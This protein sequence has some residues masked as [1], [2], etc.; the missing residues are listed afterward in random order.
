LHEPDS[1]ADVYK[2]SLRSYGLDNF[3]DIL[4]KTGLCKAMGHNQA[5]GLI[6]PKENYQKLIQKI[7]EV[8][9]GIEF[10]I[11]ID[12]DIEL[13]IKD[14][15]FDLV[16]KIQQLNLITGTGFKNVQVVL[17]NISVERLTL[18]QGKHVKFESGHI[19]IIHWN[20][21]KLF[22]E[23]EYNTE[24][25]YK[26]I[27]VCGTLSISEFAGKEKINLIISE[28]DNVNEELDFLRD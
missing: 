12:V 28:Y 4:N 25:I 23:L 2:G 19:E 24:G 3:R 16:Q 8:L 18:M 15:S 26:T 27:D 1:E 5:A 14:I 17:K 9:A 22:K 13:S 7:N 20:N 21:P 6:I 10:K 11:S